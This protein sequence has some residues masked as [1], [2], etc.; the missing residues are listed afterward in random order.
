MWLRVSMAT[1]LSRAGA[2]AARV[3]VRANGRSSATGARLPA[4]RGSSRMVAVAALAAS[5]NPRWMGTTEARCAA[6][7][8]SADGSAEDQSQSSR[9]C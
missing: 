6:A 4:S 3:V 9:H 8:R 2:H 5:L 7:Q 1:H